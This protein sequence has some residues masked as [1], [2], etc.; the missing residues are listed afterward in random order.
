MTYRVFISKQITILKEY[1]NNRMI[2]L[3]INLNKKVYKLSNN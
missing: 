3:D 1:G 2:Q